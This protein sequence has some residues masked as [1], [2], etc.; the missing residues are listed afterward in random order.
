MRLYTARD[1]YHFPAEAMQ[2]I[3]IGYGGRIMKQ[4]EDVIDYN[5]YIG[6]LQLLITNYKPLSGKWTPHQHRKVISGFP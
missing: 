2:G 4:Q 5:C 1:S 3:V 6:K